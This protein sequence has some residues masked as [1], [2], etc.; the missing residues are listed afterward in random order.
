LLKTY[1][2][3]KWSVEKAA[4]AQKGNKLITKSKQG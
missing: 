3:A 4:Q 2:T 1:A